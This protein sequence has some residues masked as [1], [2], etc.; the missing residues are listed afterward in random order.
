LDSGDLAYL[1]IQARKI[2]DKAGFQSTK[3]L[4]SNNLDEHVIGSL[5]EQGVAIDQW[6]VGTKLVTAFVSLRSAEFTNWAPSG[7]AAENSSTRLS[8]Q[9]KPQKSQIQAH[10]KSGGSSTEKRILRI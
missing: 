9:N 7:P 6:G 3:I 1:S 5:H 4:A 2:L 10:C 8:C